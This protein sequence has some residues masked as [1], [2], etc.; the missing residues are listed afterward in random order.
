MITTAAV[1]SLPQFKG[2]V[3]HCSNLMISARSHLAK[4]EPFEAA[5]AQ[6]E[7]GRALAELGWE[8]IGAGHVKHG[9]QDLLNAVHCFLEAGDYRPAE[10]QLTRLGK[11]PHLRDEVQ[12]NARLAEEYDDLL[13]ASNKT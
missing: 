3:I 2:R 6:I 13:R 10:E 12:K 7:A 11:T 1:D 4:G 9:A 5:V 8:L